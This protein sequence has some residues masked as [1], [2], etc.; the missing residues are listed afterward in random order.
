MKTC[1]SCQR[2][3]A[4]L[5]RYCIGCGRQFDRVPPTSPKQEDP[6][7]EALNLQILY[8]MVG[9]LIL[10]VLFP[11]WETPPL[12]DRACDDRHC[13]PL[14]VVSIQKKLVARNSR[15]EA[16]GLFEGRPE[17]RSRPCV[18]IQSRASVRHLADPPDFMN[19]L[20]GSGWGR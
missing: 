8:V 3:Q 12:D 13:R 1:A 15:Q 18:L 19:S 10:A 16:R 6:T 4:D 2:E 11:P 5:N 9:V 14:C 20:R 17:G 7:P